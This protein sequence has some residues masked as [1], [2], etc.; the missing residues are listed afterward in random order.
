MFRLSVCLPTFFPFCKKKSILYVLQM[1]RMYADDLETAEKRLGRAVLGFCKTF[2]FPY[3]SRLPFPPH[4]TTFDTV[5]V[6]RSVKRQLLG[7]VDTDFK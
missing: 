4:C 1:C 5:C 7:K 2:S 6:G 3:G